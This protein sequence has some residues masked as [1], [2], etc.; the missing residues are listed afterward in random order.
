VET[1]IS[2]DSS[3]RW[4]FLYENPALKQPDW[5][6]PAAEVPELGDLRA[7]HERLRAL[8]TST[9]ADY[10]ALQA[11][12]DAEEEAR[13]AAQES[14]FLG[15][16]P[17]KLVPI[18][19]TDED[20]VDAQVRAAAARDAFQSFLR[21]AVGQ[22]REREATLLDGLAAIEADA[23]AK[24]AEAQALLDEAGRLTASTL[25]MKAWLARTTGKS[26]LG[27]VAWDD[28][29]AP[30]PQTQPTLADLA[31][32]ASPAWGS[33]ELVDSGGPAFGTDN[34]DDL[35]PDSAAARPWEV[36]L[37]S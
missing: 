20:I 10:V 15:R 11:R 35:D 3:A 22:V 14:E 32:A 27:H 31:E 29:P 9:L 7:E 26:A 6:P 34:P 25:R 18:T 37:P 21:T 4:R 24:Q 28:L 12:R 33:V 5:L 2:Q 19:I 8:E 23:A 13:R 16:G 36:A 1:Q 17:A 30:V